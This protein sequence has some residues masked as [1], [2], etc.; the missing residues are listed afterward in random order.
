M[1]CNA[2]LLFFAPDWILI[3]TRNHVAVVSVLVS[4]QADEEQLLLEA[5]D[6]A[7]FGNWTA[8]SEHVGSKTKEECKV[9]HP[10]SMMR[11]DCSSLLQQHIPSA[12]S[13]A[14]MQGCVT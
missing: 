13:E 14:S 12:R 4:V 8:V 9:Q 7:G 2:T 1:Q 6:M 11:H 10:P 5:I 3:V